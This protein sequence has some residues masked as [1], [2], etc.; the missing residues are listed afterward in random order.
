MAGA[1]LRMPD[2]FSRGMPQKTC[3]PAEATRKLADSLIGVTRVFTTAAPFPS[4]IR[5]VTGEEAYAQPKP[6]RQRG[7]KGLL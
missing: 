1:P 3:V 2:P 5:P 4:C 7:E 6:S